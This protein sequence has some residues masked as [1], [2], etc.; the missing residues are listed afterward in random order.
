[1]VKLVDYRCVLSA[2][3]G[4]GCDVAEVFRVFGQ[5]GFEAWQL[6]KDL[7]VKKYVFLPSGRVQ[8]IVVGDGKDYLIYDVVGYCHCVDFYQAVMKGEAF[9]CK[10]L[11]AW[12]LAVNLNLFETILEGDENYHVRLEE[13]KN[14]GS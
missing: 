5:R 10:H 4:V 11:V 1:V 9:A 14:I 12:R 8:W 3:D 6:V 7:R 2:L 13:W